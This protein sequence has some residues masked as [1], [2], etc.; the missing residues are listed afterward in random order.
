VQRS[1]LGAAQQTSAQMGK[2]MGSALLPML[3]C[4]DFP[5]CLPM[6]LKESGRAHCIE[7]FLSVLACSSGIARWVMNNLQCRDFILFML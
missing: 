4:R 1:S 2:T 7:G 3:C 5:C 6:F